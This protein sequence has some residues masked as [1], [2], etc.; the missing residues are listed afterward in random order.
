MIL[1]II[2]LI[3][4]VSFYIYY[5]FVYK[6]RKLYDWYVKTLT[7]LGY[8]VYAIPFQ[9]FRAPFIDKIRLGYNKYGDSYYF[10]KR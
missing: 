8:K 5:K 6:P 4:A 9:A 1:Y 10:D 7:C 2:A 3:G